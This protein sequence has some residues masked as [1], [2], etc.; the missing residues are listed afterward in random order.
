MLGNVFILGDSYSTFRGYIP[1]GY[2]YYYDEEG[3][4]HVKAIPE[5]KLTDEEVSKVTQTWWHDLVC[6]NG[7]LLK[8][9]SWSGTT[10]CNTGYDGKDNSEISF[11]GRFEKL[12]NE[13]Y[14]KENRI[15]TFFLF[16]GTNDSLS[17]AP[18]GE[19]IYSDWSKEDLYNVLP[20][21]SYLIELIVSNIKDAKIYCIIN[22][23]LKEEITQFYKDVCTK[24]GVGVIELQNI[25]KSHVHP[26]VKGMM[27]IKEQVLDYIKSNQ[28]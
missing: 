25:D 13:G 7:T 10:I 15:D 18:L 3:P 8:N 24:K 28:S 5:L 19:K 23:E 2:Y 20:A 26:T 6:E 16:G 17:N 1:D 11:I 27:E 22:T 9:C 4:Y 12:V 14:F 21:F